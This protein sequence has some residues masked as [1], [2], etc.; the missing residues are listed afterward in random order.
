MMFEKD[1]QGRS[2]IRKRYQ[3]R[4]V[5][6]FCG[7]VIIGV[8]LPLLIFYLYTYSELGVTYYQ[9]LLTLKGLKQ[10]L[11]SAM[12]FTG[13]IVVILLSLA[14]LAV[15]L[16]GSHKIAGPI[17][18]L[19]KSLESIGNGDLS[20]RIKFR[21]NDAIERLANEINIATESLN[22]RICII[23][24]NIKGIREEAE[25]LRK[26]PHQSPEIL[27]EKLRLIRK[28]VSGLKTE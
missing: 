15:T 11:L 6:Q 5:T 28:E 14:I 1:R 17:Y 21:K 22:T 13:G 26:D 20:L 3:L 2:F 12:V 25:R 19:E 24:G 16:M 7:G 10:N 9:A 23:G 18:R 4:F 27:M 8:C